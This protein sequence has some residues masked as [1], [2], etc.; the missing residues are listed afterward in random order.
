MSIFPS[1]VSS[2]TTSAATAPPFTPNTAQPQRQSRHRS[3]VF[4]DFRYVTPE[5]ALF[6]IWGIW[7]R[8]FSSEA[9]PCPCVFFTHSSSTLACFNAGMFL[10]RASTAWRKNRKQMLNPYTEAVSYCWH[11]NN[12]STSSL[13]QEYCWGRG[14]IKEIWAKNKLLVVF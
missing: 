5:C 12:L 6:S 3:S 2:A 10:I 4:L 1:C 14:G 11:A 8:N 9:S 13:Q 7:R